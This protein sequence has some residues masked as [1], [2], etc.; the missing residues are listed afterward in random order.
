MSSNGTGRTKRGAW[1]G[2]AVLA[3]L[4]LGV[5]APRGV[6]AHFF[7]EEPV[8][9]REQSGLGDPQKVGPCGNEGGAAETGVVGAYVSGQTITIRLRETIFHPGHYRIALAVDDRSELPAPPPVTPGSTDCGT[10]PIMDP[11]VFPVLADGVLPHTS[12]F[13]GEQTIEVTLP[14]GVTCDHCT[15]QIVEWMSNHSAPCFYY[16][17]ADLAITSVVVDTDASVTPGTDAS[18]TPRT[19]ASTT[20]DAGSTGAMDGGATSPPPSASGG[21]AASG[22]TT[23]SSAPAL[24]A[25]VGLA[26]WLRRRG[27]ADPESL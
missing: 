14:D 17:C 21:C 15:L 20:M 22:R 24:L 11:P 9:W 6:A 16:H 1:I 5:L 4:A 23:T 13:S 25:L 7:L 18:V 12:P 10:V 27:R 2:I 3:G 19:D 8:S 26:T